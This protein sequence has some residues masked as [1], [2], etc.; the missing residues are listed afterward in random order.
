[1]LG[2]TDLNEIDRL[3][4]YEYDLLMEA[5]ELSD[6]DS[7]AKDMLLAWNTNQARATKK[8]G[9]AYF[10]SFD[11][12]FNYKRAI[13][14]KRL[15]Y[16]ADY[17]DEERAKHKSAFEEGLQAEKRFQEYLNRKEDE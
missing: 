4:L 9:E 6:I 15:E 12:F 16:E 7:M 10:K 11:Q 3:T 1:M 5:N 13:R 14:S 8:N 17:M 2:I